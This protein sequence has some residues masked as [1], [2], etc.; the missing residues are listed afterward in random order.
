MRPFAISIVL[1][2]VLCSFVNRSSGQYIEAETCQDVDYEFTSGSEYVRVEM[3]MAVNHDGTILAVSREEGIFLYNVDDLSLIR[4]LERNRF[5]TSFD[6]AWAPDE[7]ILTDATYSSPFESFRIALH[8]ASKLRLWDADTGEILQVLDSETNVVA[9]SPNGEFI[10]YNQINDGLGGINIAHSHNLQLIDSLD[11]QS[12]IYQLEWLPNSRGLVGLYDLKERFLVWQ[13]TEGSRNIDTDILIRDV[14][15]QS[16]SKLTL[17]TGRQFIEWDLAL[18]ETVSE[19]DVSTRYA[20]MQ[21]NWSYDGAMI[22]AATTDG[23]LLWSPSD[24]DSVQ[25]FTANSPPIYQMTWKP[26]GEVLFFSDY[27]GNIY[28]WDMDLTCV[29]ETVEY[30]ER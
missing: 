12:I 30:L 2:L 29:I 16:T 15:T 28:K 19:I 17:V 4:V 14:A 1:L 27:I 24:K 23:L 5:P 9:W 7:N 8:P 26:D 3:V 21:A 10:A 6:I 13:D 20:M 18:N 22:A 25:D 11:T